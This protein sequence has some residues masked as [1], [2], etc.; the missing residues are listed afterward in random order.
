MLRTYK[1]A[2]CKTNAA[3][4]KEL[5]TRESSIKRWILG[6]SNVGPRN[7]EAIAENLSS[8]ICN[9]TICWIPKRFSERLKEAIIALLAEGIS[10]LLEHDGQ[11]IRSE[12]SALT[13]CDVIS[14]LIGDKER[15]IE[16]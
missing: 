3:L 11:S 13:L 7:S 9:L 5:G 4:A 12:L 6:I 15:S 8:R 1:K 2:T 14:T 10:E 16:G